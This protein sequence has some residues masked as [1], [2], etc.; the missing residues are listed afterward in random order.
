MSCL[1]KVSEGI[2][3]GKLRKTYYGK[4]YYS[5]EGIPYA[6]PPI[7]DLRF[8]APVPP[9]S[10]TGIRDA[11]KPGEKCAQ[12]NPFGKGIV[13]GSEDCHTVTNKHE[14]CEIF[15]NTPADELVN[16]FVS[17]EINRPP[18]VINAFLLPVV[19]K[20]Y[21][22]VERFFDE[23]PLIAFRENRFNKVPIIITINSFESALFVNKDENGVVYEDLKYFIPR[24]LQIQHGTEQAVQFASKLRNYYFG[25]RKFDENVKTDYLNLTSDHYFARDT[26]LFMELVSK[27]HKDLYL[28]RF[29]YNGNVNTSTIKNMGLQGASHGDL[30]Q[31]IFYRSNKLKVASGSDVEIINMLT[32]AWCNFVKTG[33]P[34]WKT[35]QTKWL[36]YN[37]EE[38]LCLNIDNKKIEVKKY[39]NFERIQFWFDL[40]GLRAKL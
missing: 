32:E 18:A 22:G 14:L 3:E 31:Y 33:R 9:E 24:F 2:L 17:A 12:M 10:W 5:F 15:K 23:L 27:Y 35:Q 34:H 40:T 1:V 36:P 11:K 21:E 30:V 7:G 25:D 13:E 39:P 29:D 8:K 20:Y 28:C 19:E 4:Q 16:A 6:K 37:K 26:M 38:K